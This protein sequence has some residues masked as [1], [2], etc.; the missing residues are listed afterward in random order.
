ML[1][2]KNA[3]FPCMG[4]GSLGLLLFDLTRNKAHKIEVWVE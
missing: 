4:L 3:D 1:L 2:L